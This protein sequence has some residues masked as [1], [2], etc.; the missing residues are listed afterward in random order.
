M[1]PNQ[2]DTISDER[3]RLIDLVGYV[4]EGQDEALIGFIDQYLETMTRMQAVIVLNGLTLSLEWVAPYQETLGSFA[5]VWGD[6]PVF[7]LREA[8]QISMLKSM[9]EVLS[10]TTAVSAS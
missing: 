5:A 8:L 7:E 3:S 1:S 6:R 10:A 2:V 4:N 9:L